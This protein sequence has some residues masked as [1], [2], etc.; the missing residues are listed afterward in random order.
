MNHIAHSL[1]LVPFP[2]SATAC[3]TL[4]RLQ[5]ILFWGFMLSFRKQ[6]HIRMNHQ[7]LRSLR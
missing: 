5:T 1:S 2:L 4:M 6:C 7:L 3:V